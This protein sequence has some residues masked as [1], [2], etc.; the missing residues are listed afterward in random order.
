MA[1]DFEHRSF[2]EELTLC[3]RY[4]QKNIALLA[5]AASSTT[6]NLRTPLF[7]EMRSSPTVSKIA[8]D[9]SAN[10]S[11]FVFGDMIGVADM[12]TSTPS[13]TNYSGN[14]LSVAMQ[15]GGFDNLTQYRVYRHEPGSTQ[16]AIMLFT[17]EL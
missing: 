12:T 15:L 3:Q 17:A 16:Q 8:A 2:G 13:V 7:C 5:V 11:T 1:T 9:G 14:Q 6:M 4:C 10:S